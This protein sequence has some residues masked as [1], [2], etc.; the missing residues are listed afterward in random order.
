[1]DTAPWTA[2]VLQLPKG[3]VTHVYNPFFFRPR[4]CL[5][6]GLRTVCTGSAATLA[7]SA[8]G[9]ILYRLVDRHAVAPATVDGVPDGDGD[10]VLPPPPGCARVSVAT[11]AAAAAPA[12][13]KALVALDVTVMSR[14]RH[15]A[16]GKPLPDAT[17]PCH[18][19]WHCQAAAAAGDTSTVH[20]HF[21]AGM[22]EEGALRP[23]QMGL[24]GELESGA[25][26][27]RL[28]ATAATPMSLAPDPAARS[29]RLV[30][31]AGVHALRV[32]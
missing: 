2:G 21:A 1:M 19:R 8:D 26:L 23:A 3:Q 6:A 16:Q 29:L 9:R 7:W 10:D 11:A 32:P 30:S 25:M 31:A 24:P 18:L 4:T 27:M 17:V 28:P 20:A 14:L 22:A 12:R 5:E 13:R 15:A